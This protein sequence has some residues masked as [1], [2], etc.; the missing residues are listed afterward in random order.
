MDKYHVISVCSSSSA[1]YSDFYGNMILISKPYYEYVLNISN[2]HTLG[3]YICDTENNRCLFNQY[4]QSYSDIPKLNN[5]V[6]SGE[7]ISYIDAGNEI[8]CFI[9]ISIPMFDLVCVHLDAYRSDY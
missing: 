4:Y 5:T 6:F 2:I 8:K 3:D 9:R 7:K 1:W